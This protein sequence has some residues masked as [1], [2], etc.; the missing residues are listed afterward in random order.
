MK[1]GDRDVVIEALGLVDR[2]Q[3]GFAAAPRQLRDVL[4]L[5][6]HP[7]AA[8]DQHDQ[9]IGLRDGAFGL[10]NHQALDEPGVFDQTAR[11]DHDAG[12]LGAAR[13]AVL[14]IARQPRQIGD[15]RIA[16]A[17]HGVEQGRFAHIRPTDQCDYGQHV[18]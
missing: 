16:G 1:V 12:H 4:V 15:Q 3:H 18:G 2:Q 13:E 10:L 7:R 9:A 14:P 8:V 17:G 5:W 6:R 11:I